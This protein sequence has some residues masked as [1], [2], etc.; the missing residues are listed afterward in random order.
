MKQALNENIRQLRTQQGWNQVEFATRLGVTKQCVSNWENDN[1]L[2]SVEMLTRLADL[3]HVSTDHLLGREAKAV[4]DVDG[5]T[6][7]QIAHLRLLIGD[8]KSANAESDRFRQVIG[9]QKLYNP[10]DRS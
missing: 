10:Y 8:F 4:L 1:V 3:F 6:D 7:Q 9:N 2:P 5:L